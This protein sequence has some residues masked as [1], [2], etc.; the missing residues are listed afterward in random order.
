M[1]WIN[2]DETTGLGRVWNTSYGVEYRLLTSTL[3]FLVLGSMLTDRSSCTTLVGNTYKEL[4]S[5]TGL[6]SLRSRIQIIGV[7]DLMMDGSSS[8]RRLGSTWKVLIGWWRRWFARE[9]TFRRH[10]RHRRRNQRRI[11]AMGLYLHV[12]RGFRS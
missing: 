8:M 9:P 12:Q 10:R 1:L 3:A 2:T 5:T 4:T 7:Q 11:Q 6:V